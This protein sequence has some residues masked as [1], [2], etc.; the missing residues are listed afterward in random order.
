MM[1]EETKTAA[2]FRVIEGH[3]LAPIRDTDL[4]TSCVA[5]LLLLFAA[6]DGLGKL[7]HPDVNAKV[8]ERFKFFLREHM[9]GKYKTHC[10]K[11]YTLRCSL[12]HNALSLS[13]FMSRT[14][15][16]EHH[17]LEHN[18][19]VGT[20]FVSTS[21]FLR[22]FTAAL[23]RVRNLLDSDRAMMLRA[24]DRLRWVDDEQHPCWG[25]CSTPPGPIRFVTEKETDAEQA[26]GTLR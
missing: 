26:P 22:D 20:I 14:M 23:A 2:Y 3:V 18:T 21:V 9:G 24:E 8:V 1:K 12:S 15:M 10:A 13:A 7:L 4:S 17:H 25:P 6:V 5:S 19:P 16:G 11:L